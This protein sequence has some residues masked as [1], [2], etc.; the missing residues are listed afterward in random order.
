MSKRVRPLV[1][2]LVDE[3]QLILGSVELGDL[4]AA[5]RSVGRATIL[6]A[7]LHAE[8]AKLIAQ[9]QAENRARKKGN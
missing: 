7:D 9:R 2:R 8:V 6:C 1:N 4:D 3:T 5:L